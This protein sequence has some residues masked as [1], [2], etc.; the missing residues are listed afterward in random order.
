MS[1]AERN[2]ISRQAGFTLVEIIITIVIIGIIASIAANIILQGARIYSTED[3]RSNVHY[4]ARLAVER[5]AREIRMIRSASATDIT[6]GTMSA[7]NLQFYDVNNN[8]IQFQRTGASAPYTIT[9][10][11]IILANNVQSMTLSYWQL[12]GT[13]AVT[14]ATIT[15][16]WFVDISV[17]VQ[18]GT[19]T[20]QVQTRVHPMNF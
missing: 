4:Q 11:G 17:T 20:L 5:M 9:R 6:T 12:N 10:N 16:L 19:E 13:T 2:K 3:S 7:T 18:Q 1:A 8:N 14:A 15:S